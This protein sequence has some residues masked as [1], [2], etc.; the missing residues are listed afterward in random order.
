M[1]EEKNTQLLKDEVSV[2]SSIDFTV[3]ELQ[4][5]VATESIKIGDENNPSIEL[6]NDGSISVKELIILTGTGG[7]IGISKDG[8]LTVRSVTSGHSCDLRK[9]LTVGE[10]LTVGGS[11]TSNSDIYAKNKLW[12]AFGET[13]TYYLQTGKSA[14]HF[15]KG[16]KFPADS[17]TRLK[18]DIQP[19]ENAIEKL[20]QL[21]G[22]HF[23]WN[24]QGLHKKTKHVEE[25]I[26]SVS[27]TPEG[28]KK[29]W[30]AEKKRIREQHSGVYKGFI[31]QEVEKIFP[32]WVQED[33]SGHKTI[34][35]DELNVVL[36][37]AVKELNSEIQSLKAENQ[38]LKAQQTVIIDRLQ[39]LEKHV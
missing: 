17:D 13:D 28:N 32:E 27:N 25:S 33:E 10:N 4:K 15:T 2:R 6:K 20:T 16:G 9:K 19:L 30:E 12:C 8:D 7:R 24:E 22:V 34:R 18:K 31:A 23:S 38:E 26:R 36:V 35:M 37:E 3:E 5:L 29:A 21:Q 11:I 1:N 14:A 39:A